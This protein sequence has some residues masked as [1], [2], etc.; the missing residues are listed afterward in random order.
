MRK[1]IFGTLL[2]VEFLLLC[3]IGEGVY[4]G[5]PIAN[6]LWCLPLFLCMYVS[7]KLAK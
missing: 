7:A 3:G 2:F 1:K 6:V 4:Q 5:E